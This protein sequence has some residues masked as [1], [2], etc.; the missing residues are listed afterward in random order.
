MTTQKNTLD[1][2]RGVSPVLSV[3]FRSDGEV[4]LPGFLRV[5]DHVLHTGV[6][7]CLLFGLVGEFAKLTDAE[8]SELLGALLSRS[9]S[10][11]DFAAIAS[12]TE[13]AAE[14]AVRRA[15]QYADMGVDA[16]NILPP[17]FLGPSQEHILNHV[18]AVCESVDL[19]VILQ[20][21]PKQTGISI[22]ARSIVALNERCP[23]LAL[24]KVES[25]PAGRLVGELLRLSEGR[26]RAFVGYAGLYWPDAHARGAVGVQPGCS[27]T[28]IYVAAQRMID[29][30]DERS[31]AD[32]HRRALPWLSYWMQSVELI[33]A[34]EKLILQQRGLVQSAYCRAPGYALDPVEVAAVNSFLAEFEEYLS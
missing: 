17:S 27:F 21:A 2:L 29:D 25:Q 13:H 3:P 5:V 7:S 23:N 8:S 34:V 20:Y 19:P 12:I 30:G 10:R 22:P 31:F 6:S 24:V 16:I 11:G 14:T 9:S 26:L 18:A 4:D 1:L 28:E 33:V 32:L 15:E